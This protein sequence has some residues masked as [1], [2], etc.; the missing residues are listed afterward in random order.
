MHLND[1][2]VFLFSRATATE[3]SPNQRQLASF[4][5]RPKKVNSILG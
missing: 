3:N 1:Q 5:E 2:K 4:T